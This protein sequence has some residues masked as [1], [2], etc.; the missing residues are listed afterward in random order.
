MGWG[1]L[2]DEPG[3]MFIAGA[4]CQ[5]WKADVVFTPIPADRF[6]ASEEP[7]RVKIVWTLEAEPLDS[8]SSRFASETRVRAMDSEAREKFRRY[9]RTFSIGI[10]TIRLFLLP[11]IRRE[12]ERRWRTASAR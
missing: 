9:W 12:A 3:R 10:L 5:P 2:L 7:G 11:A 8:T 4:S 1:V 6:A